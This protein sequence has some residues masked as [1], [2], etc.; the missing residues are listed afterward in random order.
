MN[1]F[2]NAALIQEALENAFAS[3]SQDIT[4]NQLKLV[5]LNLDKY[6]NNLELFYQ[7]IENQSRPIIEQYE[8]ANANTQ[9]I[10]Y[11]VFKQLNYSS[12]EIE[13]ILKE[14]YVLMD[15]IRTFFTGEE[16]TY[17]IGIPYRGALYEQSISLEELLKYTK[18]DF[19]TKSK[20]DNIFKLRMTNKKDMRTAFQEKEAAVSSNVKDGSTVY[21]AVWHYLNTPGADPRN[22]N[23]GNA[24]EVYRVLVAKRQ[25]HNRIPPA[26]TI[27]MIEDAFTEVRSNTASSIKGGDFLT[28]Q[29]KYFSSAPSLATTSLIRNTLQELKN[30]FEKFLQ[31]ANINEFKSSIKTMFLKDSSVIDEIEQGALL[32]ASQKID[33]II[34]NL[35][36]DN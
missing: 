28:S 16:I 33:E 8:S 36:F 35:R 12:A 20:I 34:N 22:K 13:N 24:Y 18:I 11:A 32:E 5:V 25:N 19:N 4:K 1:E 2:Q 9:T 10:S 23:L 14:G 27:K 29:I 7:N 30:N 17:Q 31:S 15:K 3:S 21:S 6:L 26:V